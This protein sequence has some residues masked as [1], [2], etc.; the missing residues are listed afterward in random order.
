MDAALRGTLV[1]LVM[2]NLMVFFIGV[3][4]LVHLF[5][6]RPSALFPA[7]TG[8]AGT[9]V[10]REDAFDGEDMLHPAAKLTGESLLKLSVE[11]RWW[12]ATIASVAL[13]VCSTITSLCLR[14]VAEF[15]AELDAEAFVEDARH[16]R[17]TERM[18]LLQ[19]SKGYRPEHGAFLFPG[20]ETSRWR[21]DSVS[22]EGSPRRVSD[23]EGSVTHRLIQDA[24]SLP[25]Q[26][27]RTSRRNVAAV[28]SKHCTGENGGDPSTASELHEDAHQ[29]ETIGEE[30]G[31]V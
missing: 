31:R 4:L 17:D 5:S 25:H 21:R 28:P 3:F 11:A 16:L 30:E 22:R 26:Q 10:Q 20:S 14:A 29:I 18:L 9:G 19:A 6:I 27:R 24:K 12:I 13:V 23:E 1:L 7:D 8:P 15:Q 2:E